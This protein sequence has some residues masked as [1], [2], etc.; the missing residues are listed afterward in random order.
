[1]YLPDVNVLLAAA[2]G[3]HPHHAPAGQWLNGVEEQVMLC[4]VTQMGLLRLLTLRTVMR[5][6]V[7][8]RAGA[9]R[10]LDL[11][12]RDE[13]VGW[14]E[15]PASTDAVWRAL[16]AREDFSSKLWTDDYLAALAQ[17]GGLTLVTLDR[18]LAER[19]P[20]VETLTLGV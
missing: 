8:T 7:I 9:W 5:E 14:L 4:R 15:E 2:W 18:A 20:S 13:R 3:R 12:R 1:M 16:S 11:L 19:H 10:L 6:D 17:A